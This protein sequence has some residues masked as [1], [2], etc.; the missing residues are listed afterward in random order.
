MGCLFVTDDVQRAMNVPVRQVD[1]EAVTKMIEGINNPIPAA[2][3][4]PVRNGTSQTDGVQ[5]GSVRAENGDAIELSAAAR[6]Q[7]E[8]SESPAIRTELVERVRSEIAAGT[9]LTDD[10]IDAV[11]DRLMHKVM[12]A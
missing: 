5:D 7:L 1:S 8:R 2:A 3:N 11:I 6:Q 10:K 12:A 9:Y 4:P